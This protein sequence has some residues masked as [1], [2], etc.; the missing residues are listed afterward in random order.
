MLL[1]ERSTNMVQRRFNAPCSPSLADACQ[2]TSAWAVKA[3]CGAATVID[4]CPI[5]FHMRRRQPK[6]IPVRPI[7][8]D[9]MLHDTTVGWVQ[10][11]TGDTRHSSRVDGAYHD[12]AYDETH[13]GVASGP[14]G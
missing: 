12:N 10:V 1:T 6:L 3:G 7:R 13:G 5:G 2:H 9:G 8:D 11:S 14:L 4:N